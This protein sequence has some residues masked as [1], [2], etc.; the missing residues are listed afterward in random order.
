[1]P[2]ISPCGLVV[3]FVR[4]CFKGRWRFFPSRPDVYTTG[5]HY[6]ADDNTPTV[7][8]FHPFGS[9]VWDKD[10]MSYPVYPVGEYM[11]DGHQ[12]YDGHS[13]VVVAPPNQIFHTQQFGED[14]SFPVVPPVDVFNGFDSR[15]WIDFPPGFD[16]DLDRFFRPDIQNCCWQRVL[17]RMLELLSEDG[18]APLA[19]VTTAAGMLWG[20]ATDIVITPLNTTRDRFL[21]V[22]TPA[23]Q[24][25]LCVG[26]QTWEETWHQAWHG[27]GAPVNFGRWSTSTTWL[28]AAALL[29]QELQRLHFDPDKPLTIVGH[30]R[31][32]A[33]VWI[34]ARQMTDFNFNRNVDVLTFESPKVGDFRM[35]QNGNLANTRHI[36]NQEDIIP[37]VPPNIALIP[38]LRALLPGVDLDPM[39]QWRNYSVYQIIGGGQPPRIAPARELPALRDRRVHSL[40]YYRRCAESSGPAFHDLAGYRV[41]GML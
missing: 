39:T 4:S 6:F 30:S 11:Q 10:G 5:F 8:G 12:Y 20:D 24:V 35:I 31:G 21:W 34:L 17:A 3:D 33:K 13:P 14:F 16:L 28:Q 27:L 36:I 22:N 40:G 18:A 19:P 15:C 29:A 32:A 23:F 26:T 38:Q 7:R 41:G 25:V 9:G 2:P 1:M 37:L